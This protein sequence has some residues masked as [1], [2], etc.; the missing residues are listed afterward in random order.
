MIFYKRHDHNLW[1]QWSDFN[2][3]QKR[4][5]KLFRFFWT[6]LHL[7]LRFEC[8]F[9]LQD[10]RKVS[11]FRIR[12]VLR[13]ILG[14]SSI[15][16]ACFIFLL[17]SGIEVRAS[18]KKTLRVNL[19][20]ATQIALTNYYLL[21]SLKN[22]NTAIKELIS[23][24]WRDLLPTLG[25]N[26]TRQRYIIQDSSDYIYNAILLN[27]D[28]I[29]YDGGKKK[30]DLDIAQLEEILSREDFKITS[31]KVRLEVE[32]T[33]INT[34]VALAKVALNKKSVERAKEQLRLAK[35]EAKLGF[36]TQIQVLS[37]ASRLQEIEFAL[38]KSI[39]EYLKAKNDLK[40]VMS[41]D[42][43]SDLVIEGNLLTDFYLSYPDFKRETL[44]EN[45]QN[46]RS[47]VVRI[48]IN[49]KKLAKERE[50]A[51]N[52][53]IPQI[54][55]GGSYGRTGVTYPLQ[56]DTWNMNVKVVFP[57][58]GSTNTTTENLG[59]RYNNQASSGF[60]GTVN[61]NFNAATSNNLQVLD[62][63]SYSR[64]VMESKIKLGDSIAE[65]NA[66]SSPSRSKWR[67]L[68]T[69]LRNPTI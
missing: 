52:A 22:K 63:M 13:G 19:E 38:V 15:L 46:Q 32:K 53:W 31:S 44:I 42:H 34:L 45:A 25:V 66:W 24:R 68:A 12:K 37:V 65:K 50:L 55:I 59:M 64:K 47:E 6:S 67:K 27:V 39:N 2:K 56:N 35:L 8:V 26:M 3:P 58:G 23:E 7:A 20:T 60:A 11:I 49:N 28:Q 57:L 21:L 9:F 40:L 43:Q 30:L 29:I 18:D 10:E 54:S 1:P 14:G 62:N 33:F 51:E 41:L 36:T 69:S 48:K 4:F 61:P 17:C 16:F 5:R